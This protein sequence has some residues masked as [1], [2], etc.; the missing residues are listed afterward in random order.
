[1]IGYKE[2][3]MNI[4]EDLK[5]GG[6]LYQKL[7]DLGLIKKLFDPSGF[8]SMPDW[9]WDIDIDFD[10]ENLLRELEEH[11]S[12]LVYFDGAPKELKE[13]MSQI[14][15]GLTKVQ[16]FHDFDFLMVNCVN[17]GIAGFGLGRKCR[18]F[19]KSSFSGSSFETGIEDFANQIPYDLASLFQKKYEDLGEAILNM[20]LL[21]GNIDEL[22]GVLDDGPDDDDLYWLEDSDEGFSSEAIQSMITSYEFDEETLDAF[23]ECLSN[24]FPNIDMGD[25]DTGDY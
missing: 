23:K 7:N 4:F 22:E 21:P 3:I 18:A 24:Y 10:D 8:Q 15:D 17:E 6:E 25:L 16:G 1:M 13:E 5:S 11:Q 20:A 2:A 12:F 9:G 14:Y 19:A